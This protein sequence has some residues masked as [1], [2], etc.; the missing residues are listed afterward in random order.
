M[1]NI[2]ISDKWFH[3]KNKMSRCNKCNS[4]SVC[5]LESRSSAEIGHFKSFC[6]FCQACPNEHITV[7]ET[8]NNIGC[9]L[10]CYY[11]QHNIHILKDRLLQFPIMRCSFYNSYYPRGSQ[12]AD[13]HMARICGPNSG[14]N[15]ACYECSRSDKSREHAWM[16][17]SG[18]TMLMYF[19]N[20]NASLKKSLTQDDYQKY[21]N[22]IVTVREKHRLEREK[23]EKEKLEQQQRYSSQYSY[24]SSYASTDNEQT[25][26]KP[27]IYDECYESDV[28]KKEK[29]QYEK[30][31]FKYSLFKLICC[32]YCFKKTEYVF[33][34]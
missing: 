13:L 10:T 15:V 29:K 31:T 11:Q 32:C 19:K 26:Y 20:N 23:I 30:P 12:S 8:N 24:A 5:V 4:N 28:R 22:I 16:S 18:Y 7:F 2:N 6:V 25:N 34:S 21:H 1:T 33:I 27:K 3:D 14:G 17:A 9:C